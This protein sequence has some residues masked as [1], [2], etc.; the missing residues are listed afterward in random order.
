MMSS[1]SVLGGSEA[2]S[3]VILGF[4]GVQG[5]GIVGPHDVFTGA[6][7]LTGGGYR[8]SVVSRD[9][10]P[11]ATST[12]LAFVAEAMPEPRA[13]DTLV[14]PCGS[15]VDPARQDPGNISWIKSAALTLVVW[16]A[17]APV[18]FWLLRRVSST[19]VV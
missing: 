4:P 12:S 16:S 2:R 14:L 15:G 11:V 9:G 8:V 6:A 5:L 13:V 17:C 3:V 7:L 19:A 18:R 1:P 10:Q